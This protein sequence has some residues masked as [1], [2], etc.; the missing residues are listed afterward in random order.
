MLQVLKVRVR[1]LNERQ[2]CIQQLKESKGALHVLNETVLEMTDELKRLTSLQ[3]RYAPHEPIKDTQL[4]GT[5]P[6]HSTCTLINY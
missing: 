3:S 5:V 6:V 2:M 4:I 1:R